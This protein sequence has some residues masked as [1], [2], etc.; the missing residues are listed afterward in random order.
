MDIITDFFQYIKEEG[1]ATA[2]AAS[3]SGMGNVVA[4]QPA[5]APG[6]TVTGNGTTGSGDVGMPLFN[7][8]H[9]DGANKV[10][11]KK[12]TK[13]KNK[14]VI[15]NFIANYKKGKKNKDG[16]VKSSDGNTSS[17][18]LTFSQFVNNDITK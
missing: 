18:M 6:A 13:G 17:K 16:S 9:Q 2:G 11:V 14:S 8:F 15:Q 3:V 7:T 5:S 1:V 4:A 10:G 12:G